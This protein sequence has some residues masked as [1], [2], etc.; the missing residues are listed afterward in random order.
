MKSAGLS[1][2]VDGLPAPADVDKAKMTAQL[3]A[4]VPDRLRFLERSGFLAGKA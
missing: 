2:L 4:M 1:L 3:Q